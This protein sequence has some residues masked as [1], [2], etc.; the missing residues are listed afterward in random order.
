MVLADDTHLTGLDE[1]LVRDV[2]SE[3]GEL[4]R[5]SVLSYLPKDE[6]RSYLYELVA[7]YPCRG[8]KMLRSSLCIAMARATGA[9]IE[10]ALASAASIELLHNAMLVHDDIEDASSE[11]RGSPTL[12]ALHGTPLAINAGDAMGLLGLRPLKDN[13]HRLGLSTAL[14]VFEETERM[15]WESAEGQALELGW[16]RDNRTD[17]ADEDYLR[18]ALQKTCWLLAIYPMRVGSLIGARGRMPLDPLIRIG[19]FFGA[20][21]QIQDDLLNLEPGPGY[22]KERNGDLLE[23]KRTLMIIHALR[24]SSAPERGKLTEYL[25][26]DRHARTDQD[27]AWLRGLMDRTGALRHARTVAYALAGAALC[28]FDTYFSGAR[29]SRDLNF[30]RSLFVWV[31]RRSH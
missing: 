5:K 27:I 31:L 17:L 3:Y 24:E 2:L 30:I 14:A 4:T 8:G 26:T 11:R 28:E 15:A 29:E 22:G 13:F 16:R 6:P 23:G 10:D 19:F 12:H 7:D 25:G 21:F 1:P 9:K 20:A 18:M